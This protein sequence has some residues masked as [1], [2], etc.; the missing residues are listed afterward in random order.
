MLIGDTDNVIKPRLLII[1]LDYHAEV[2][3]AICPILATRFSLT[4]WTTD[5]IWREAGLSED[6]FDD[7]LIMPK[8]S[9]LNI[10]WRKY[11]K[12]FSSIDLVYFNTL[13][14]NF[15]FFNSVN[16][17]CPTIMRIHNVNASLFPFESIDW[18]LLK[19]LKV[20]N[21]LLRKVVLSRWWYVRKAL[22][23]KMDLLMLPNST[24]VKNF[25]AKAKALGYRNISNYCLPF[26][27]L[28]EA[29]NHEI[30]DGKV[31]FAITGAVDPKRKE[32]GSLLSAIRLFKERCTHVK[33]RML[34][35][36][37]PKGKAGLKVVSQ[38]KLLE[39]ERFE[40]EYYRDYVPNDVVCE[41]ML[42]VQFLVAPIKLKAK[43]KI[44]TEYYGGSKISG[45]ESD[46][47]NYRK[48]VILPEKYNLPRELQGVGFTYSSAEGLCHHLEALGVRAGY[49][50]ASSEFDKMHCYRKESIAEDFYQLYQN[51]NSSHDFV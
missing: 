16:F 28:G 9:S 39:D 34:L 17:D 29:K 43:H 33:L 25:E 48:P 7:L 44:H 18:S 8:N 41:K 13:E 6:Y 45:V 46:V 31:V 14:K 22:Y 38:F 23:F 49:R 40:L 50:C 36:G 24:I 19:T 47:V 12:T 1:E 20:F 51:I 11:E 37:A 26:F 35:L 10:F 5:R 27:S 30:E 2:L 32:Y 42:K 21:Y 4:I 3:R 15:S